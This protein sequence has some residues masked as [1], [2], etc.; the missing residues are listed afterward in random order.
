VAV[1]EEARGLGRVAVLFEVEPGAPGAQAWTVRFALDDAAP[2]AVRDPSRA[3]VRKPGRGT[4]VFAAWL[5]GPAGEVLHA[6]AA[7]AVV[8]VHVGPGAA[9]TAPLARL[10][11]AAPWGPVARSP[12]GVRVDVLVHGLPLVPGRRHL[13]VEAGGGRL[14]LDAP[15]PA[16]L[17]ALPPGQHAV[18][19]RLVEK[20]SAGDPWSDV[21][22]VAL[23]RVLTVE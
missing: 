9:A 21:A 3:L 11:W 10:T 15:G 7:H 4:H 12:D 19:A 5:T 14:E 13:C 20:R 6:P 1:W 8:R 17:P 16:W 22:G 2:T 23:E 18:R